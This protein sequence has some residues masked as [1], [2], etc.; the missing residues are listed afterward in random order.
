MHPKQL[1]RDMKY[2]SFGEMKSMMVLLP[3]LLRLQT[4]K[5]S[6]LLNTIAR[7]LC[8]WGMSMISWKRGIQNT[9]DSL[10]ARGM[11][12]V[13]ITSHILMSYQ[14]PST[15]RQEKRRQSMNSNKYILGISKKRRSLRVVGKCLVTT[16]QEIACFCE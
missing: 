12:W 15:Y 6:M 1:D 8:H 7:T 16:P 13:W 5:R 14:L 11:P 4:F 10:G 9:N 2:A 3:V